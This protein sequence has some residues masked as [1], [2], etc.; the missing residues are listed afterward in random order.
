[1]FLA[2]LNVSV[3]ICYYKRLKSFSGKFSLT[4]DYCFIRQMDNAGQNGSI[5]VESHE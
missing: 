2:F 1:M 5:H 4:P 3:S